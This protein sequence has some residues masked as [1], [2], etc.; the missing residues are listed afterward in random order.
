MFALIIGLCSA[1]WPSLIVDALTQTNTPT[2]GAENA[3][4][5]QVVDEFIA[6]VE[7]RSLALVIIGAADNGSVALYGSPPF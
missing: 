5:I 3:D 2:S 6:V 4:T 1:L 7:L